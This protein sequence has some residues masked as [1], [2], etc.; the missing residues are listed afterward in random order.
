MTDRVPAAMAEALRLTQA[1]DLAGATALIQR[2]LRGAAPVPPGAAPTIIDVEPVTVNA[3]PDMP[4]AA[5]PRRAT[6]SR[7]AGAF[8][9]RFHPGPRTGLGG[10]LRG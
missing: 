10:T 5:P 7:P 9:G 8:A 3:P 1:G 2:L 4:D 6:A